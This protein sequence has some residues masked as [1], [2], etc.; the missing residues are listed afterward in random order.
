M[1]D[2]FWKL[3]KKFPIGT[4]DVKLI[5]YKVMKYYYLAS[6]C[7]KRR[8]SRLS[9]FRYRK[10]TFSYDFHL[11]H[12]I[13]CMM[14]DVIKAYLSKFVEN[15]HL[16]LTLLVFGFLKLSDI[17]SGTIYPQISKFLFLL[18]SNKTRTER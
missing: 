7:K 10:F 14:F 4:H 3:W 12:N 9:F 8:D 13:F 6:L 18:K 5:L 1:I 11:H 17:D 16:I 15:V 2:H